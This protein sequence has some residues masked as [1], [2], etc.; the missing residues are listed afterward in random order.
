MRDLQAILREPAV[1]ARE[2]GVTSQPRM[3]FVLAGGGS[4]GALQVTL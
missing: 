3:A 2:R 4:L 1:Y